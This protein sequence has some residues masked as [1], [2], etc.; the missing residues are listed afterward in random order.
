VRGQWEGV[1]VVGGWV[2]PECVWL[3]ECGSAWEW[4]EGG[5]KKKEEGRRRRKEERGK[6]LIP[7]WQHSGHKQTTML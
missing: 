6:I 7:A 2:L 1:M 4:D 3:W 5:R